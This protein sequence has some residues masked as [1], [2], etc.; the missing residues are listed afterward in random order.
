MEKP[1]FC[2]ISAV[3]QTDGFDYLK[4][5]CPSV[6]SELLECVA[7]ISEHSVISYGYRNE[8]SLDGADIN[9]R[10]VKQRIY[11]AKKQRSP[12]KIVIYND[13]TLELG[14]FWIGEQLINHI[15]SINGFQAKTFNWYVNIKVFLFVQTFIPVVWLYLVTL[16]FV[17]FAGIRPHL[18]VI[19]MVL[20][21]G[22]FSD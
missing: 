20:K 4:Q 12:L 17:M 21:I 14:N 16:M 11:W 18:S 3:M 22:D 19:H 2:F 15:C 5:S 6:I 1:P 13:C 8:T 9:G 7:R 10:R